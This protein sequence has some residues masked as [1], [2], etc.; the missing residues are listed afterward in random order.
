MRNW[1]KYTFRLDSYKCGCQHNCDYCYSKN[2]LNFR[3]LWNSQHP[4]IVPIN[5]NALIVK[6]LDRNIVVRL[7]GMTDCFQP[8]EVIEKATYKTILW[9]N[10]YKIHYLIVTKS[11]LV[12]ND[13]YLKIYDP[14]LAHF[15]ISISGT[16]DKKCLE[17]ENASP[18]SERIKS[19]E[20][21]YKLGFDISVRLSPFII[22]YCDTDIINLIQCDKILI[23]FLKVGRWIKKWFNIDYTDYSLKCGGYEHLQ[24]ESKNEMVNKITGFNQI[25]VGEFIVEHHKYFSE[26][27]NFNPADCCNLNYKKP[28]DNQLALDLK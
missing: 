23:E 7:G 10:R 20:L 11:S 15:Q 12:S 4:K 6:S 8:L 5:D 17:Y 25:S 1:C 3:N 19:I 28:A 24:L 26:N 2:L 27:V 14:K 13:E 9:L 18:V 22:Q 21:L 16:D